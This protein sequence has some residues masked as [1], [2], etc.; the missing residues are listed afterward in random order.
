M[1]IL[2]S[3]FK[4]LPILILSFI[5]MGVQAQEDVRWASKLI[6]QFNNFGDEVF[7][8]KQVLGPPDAL[9]FG[10]LNEKAFRIKYVEGMGTFTVGFESPVK[11]HNI[12]IAESND[13][14]RVYKVF[15]VDDQGTE[16]KVYDAKPEVLLV[17]YRLLKI[18]VSKIKNPIT[19]VK[20]H[21]QT[22]GVSGWPQV[23]AVGLSTTQAVD[24]TEIEGFEYEPSLQAA[25]LKQFDHEKEYLGD[26][27]NTPFP[28][29]K[30]IISPDGHTLYFHRQNA[31]ENLGGKKD[32]Q[33]IYYSRLVNGAWSI[34]ENI[35]EPL[36]DKQANGICAVSPDGN[37]IWVINGYAEDGNITD[38]ISVSK[39]TPNGW[40]YPKKVIIEDYYNT[41][42]Y[43][44]F[45]ISASGRAMIL[46]IQRD[47]SHGD[48]DLYVSFKKEEDVWSRPI[49]IGRV[50]NTSKAE[51]A[52]FLAPDNR[53]LYFSSNGHGGQGES[54]IFMTKR[55]DDTWQ[56]W[57]TPQN[58]SGKVNTKGFDAYYTISARGDFAYFV[59]GQNEENEDLYRISLETGKKPDPIVLYSGTVYN[60][61]TDEPI[62][63]DIIYYSFPVKDEEGLAFT[64]P[65]EGTFKLALPRGRKYYIMALAEGYMS[66][67][68]EEDFT[69]V[70]DF[71]EVKEKIYLTPLE[72]GQRAQLHNL[73]FEQSKAALLPES[74]P[75]LQR[76]YEIM[77]KNQSLVIEI[78]GHTDNQGG[79]D[80][81]V[82]LSEQRAE[83][84]KD[85]LTE[86]GIEKRR[87]TS[88]GYGPTRP[89]ASNA[90]E[91]T[92]KLNRRVE[93]EILDY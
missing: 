6:F 55:L 54:D 82:E 11:A 83:V 76:L 61:K 78:S 75:E 13:P 8:G 29:V 1:Q 22:F 28:E 87:I 36:N 2:H 30:P 7:S 41:S 92:R 58:L 10:K 46:A 49:N 72:I 15:A 77:E 80:A 33:D 89:I 37:T 18:D 45:V 67:M 60:K 66:F 71:K 9:P 53:T 27:I 59:T 3:M 25:N 68:K 40:S 70:S 44:D 14:G 52:P 64:L 39:R 19:E 74:E 43:Q 20:V 24:E 91:E 86:R 84:V 57:S 88:K 5:W 50:V 16:Y 73:Q 51:Y 90:S 23:D 81:N 26:V 34:P 35:G 69:R 17:P 21:L 42:P 4:K 32:D 62:A 47:D 63:S 31:K 85:Y 65:G 12:L 38:G 48:Q 56:K 79:F 93:I